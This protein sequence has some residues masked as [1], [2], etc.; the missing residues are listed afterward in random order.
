MVDEE[1]GG[2]IVQIDPVDI[3]QPA[4][5]AHALV[6]GDLG[7]FPI[8][9]PCPEAVGVAGQERGILEEVMDDLAMNRGDAEH[10]IPGAH[11]CIIREEL[12]TPAQHEGDCTPLLRHVM[13]IIIHHAVS[14]P[15]DRQ[16]RS[17]L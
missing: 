8:R 6:V 5:I 10:A 14:L 13:K 1:P 9:H 2:R 4:V 3:E 11:Q 15:P 16:H 12:L 7:A 17:I